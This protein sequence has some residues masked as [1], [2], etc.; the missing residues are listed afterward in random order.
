MTE[1]RFRDRFEAYIGEPQQQQG[2]KLLHK[3]IMRLPGGAELL[4]EESEWAKI[5]SR[6]P[7]TI[8]PLPLPYFPQLDNGPEGWRQC[9]TSAIAMNLAF[10]KVPR[11]MD[12]RD[13]LNIVEQYGD[14]TNQAA[15]TR[16]LTAMKAPGHFI[17][18][19]TVERAKA[20]IDKG[21]GLAIGVL[22]H[23][24]VSAPSGGGHYVAV[25]GYDSRGWYVHDPYGELD[26]VRGGWTREGGTTGKNLH[27]SFKNLNPRWLPEGPA[28]GW[29]WIFS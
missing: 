5:F 20:E 17:Q 14:T 22:H 4:T 1:K 11:I 10:L 8:N 21:F 24:P 7:P 13:Y 18:N 3:E 12:D 15:H 29:A 26:L 6:R 27:Y 9:Q 2:V 25:R 16:A 28:S 19:C 23:G